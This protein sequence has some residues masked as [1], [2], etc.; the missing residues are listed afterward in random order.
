MKK[1]KLREAQS[2]APL[3]TRDGR[4]A[5]IVCFNAKGDCKVLA[6]VETTKLTAE[7]ITSLNESAMW[8]KAGGKS[9]DHEDFDLFLK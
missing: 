8:Y 2:G 4:N 9:V 5:R 3:C 6:L 7:G 1:F